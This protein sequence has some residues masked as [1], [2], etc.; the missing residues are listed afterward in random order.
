MKFPP[1]T[2]LGRAAVGAGIG[3]VLLTVT[4]LVLKA[5]R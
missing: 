4:L 1:E 2:F 3:A 5:V